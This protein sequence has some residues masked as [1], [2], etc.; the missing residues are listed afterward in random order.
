MEDPKS[1]GKITQERVDKLT[2]AGFVWNPGSG[3][4]ADDVSI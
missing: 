2:Q 4:I 1:T 3:S